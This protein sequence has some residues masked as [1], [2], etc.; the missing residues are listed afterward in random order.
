[1]SA[2]RI[3]DMGMTAPK[4]ALMDQKVVL[5]RTGSDVWDYCCNQPTAPL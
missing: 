3:L 2:R 5:R 1:M 4:L